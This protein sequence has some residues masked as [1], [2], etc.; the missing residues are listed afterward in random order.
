MPEVP[1]WDVDVVIPPNDVTIV[2]DLVPTV[3]PTLDLS[4]AAQE[5]LNMLLG[6]DGPIGPPGLPGP[7]GPSGAMGTIADT[8]WVNP[9]LLNSWANYNAPTWEPAGYRKI[10]DVVY[11]RGMLK[12]GTATTGTTILTL[13]AGYRPGGNQHISVPTSVDPAS[14]INLMANGDVLV[15][16]AMPGATWCSIANISFP[17]DN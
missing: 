4:L 6:G 3:P 2:I 1:G 17:A 10:G 15:N 13:P 5:S 9:I 7:A 8:G 14:R 12:P 11:L 16:V